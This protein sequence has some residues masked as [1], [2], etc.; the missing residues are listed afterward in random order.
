MAAESS[1]WSWIQ[2]TKAG[3]SDVNSTLGGLSSLVEGSDD[4]MVIVYVLLGVGAVTPVVLLLTTAIVLRSR[5]AARR[6]VRRRATY[7]SAPTVDAVVDAWNSSV[8]GGTSNSKPI[9]AGARSSRSNSVDGRQESGTLSELAV[10]EFFDVQ[11]HQACQ[12][13]VSVEPGEGPRSTKSGT[14]STSTAASSTPGSGD[15]LSGSESSGEMER[16]A[17]DFVALIG[18]ASV[19]TKNFP[20]TAV[21]ETEKTRN[22]TSS[23]DVTIQCAPSTS[24]ATSTVV[25]SIPDSCLQNDENGSR[26]ATG[27]G[28]TVHRVVVDVEP[29]PV[30]GVAD[31]T[32]FDEETNDEDEQHRTTLPCLSRMRRSEACYD[33]AHLSAS[34]PVNTLDGPCD[35]SSKSSSPQPSPAPPTAAVG[36]SWNGTDT[37]PTE[38]LFSEEEKALK[39]L[40][41]IA[42]DYADNEEVQEPTEKRSKL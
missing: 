3:V 36:F 26:P 16:R 35:N 34:S 37:E 12:L 20:E 25:A 28:P 9:I 23:D 33:I 38:D 7:N 15:W 10:R 24:T 14:A 40:D 42:Y 32:G 13:Y 17:E 39:C 6:G 5:R 8:A 19:T 2:P 29:P 18:P 21:I 27:C 41:A 22:Q 30:N 4:N 11:D 1:T 31:E